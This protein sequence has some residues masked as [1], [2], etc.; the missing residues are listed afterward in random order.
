MNKL[1]TFALASVLLLSAGTASAA[2]HG[3]KG[4]AKAPATTPHA[5][6][7]PGHDMK[8]MRREPHHLL[9]MA[10]H[11]SL[12][13]FAKALGE[14][15]KHSGTVN[16]EFVRTAVTE[17]RRDYD[18]M[19]QHHQAH[20]LTMSAEVKAQMDTMMPVMMEHQAQVNKA[21]TALEQEVLLATPDAKKIGTLAA[22]IANHLDG[23][24]NCKPMQVAT[25][26]KAKK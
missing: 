24:A 8:M 10:F 11:Q 7:E 3:H 20:V 25:E 16:S 17:M 26:S 15:T 19:K 6:G 4:A 2:D 9:A 5:K 1:T 21:L 23:M 13:N 22:S 12:A 14:G 18:A